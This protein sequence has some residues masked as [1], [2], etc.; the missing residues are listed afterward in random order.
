MKLLITGPPGSGKTTLCELIIDRLRGRISVGGFVSS[1]VLDGVVRKGFKLRDIR[2][3]KEG[4][5][6]SVDQ[7]VGPRVGKYVVNLED[8]NSVGVGAIS[9]ALLDCDLIIIDEIGP[10]ELFSEE[11][12][13]VVKEAFGSKKEVIATIQ[14][15]TRDK[16]IKKLGLRDVPLKL[17]FEEDKERLF[18]EVV[19]RFSK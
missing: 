17:M 2:S 1:A 5:L 16:L 19:G 15:G 4:V 13:A 8:L 7:V 14:F 18:D 12:V 9:K 3:F 6:A 10:M 11:F